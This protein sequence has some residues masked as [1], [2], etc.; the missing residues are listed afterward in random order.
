MKHLFVD[1]SG[2]DALADKADK[3]HA[4]ALQFRNEI[5]GKCKLVTTNYIMGFLLPPSDLQ[6]LLNTTQHYL[7]L[8]SFKI[9]NSFE[10]LE[11]F[12]S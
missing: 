7:F 12:I 10:S 9:K 2:W 4:K 11:K 3:D 5:I 1:T 8:I 6:P